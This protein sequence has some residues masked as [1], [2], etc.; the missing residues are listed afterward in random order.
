M[1]PIAKF[2][3]VGLPSW[4]LLSVVWSLS[5]QETRAEALTRLA[6]TYALGFLLAFVMAVT[7]MVAGQP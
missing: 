6:V 1:S 7:E 5:V 3:L 4:T 2:I